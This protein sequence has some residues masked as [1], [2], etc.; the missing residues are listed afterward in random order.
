MRFDIGKMWAHERNKLTMYDASLR[1]ASLT[2]SRLVDFA[3][4][5]LIQF[6]S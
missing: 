2:L 4:P 1:D 6:Y 3:L 5:V